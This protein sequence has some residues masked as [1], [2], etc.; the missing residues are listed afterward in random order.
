MSR[1]SPSTARWSS[2]CQRI[3]G[4]LTCRRTR[5]SAAQIAGAAVGRAGLG[6][7]PARRPGFCDACSNPTG[8]EAVENIAVPGFSPM[9]DFRRPSSAVCAPSPSSSAGRWVLGEAGKQ[10]AVTEQL[11]TIGPN[12]LAS[13][14]RISSPPG[15]RPLA[16]CGMRPLNAD[17]PNYVALNAAAAPTS[18]IRQLLEVHS[19]RDGT[20]A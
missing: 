7:C 14:P 16:S 3:L 5:L 13:I 19:R 1:W 17:K 20:D 15:S 18:P 9:R 6:R 4:R 8:G 11:D 2:D 12:L 10:A